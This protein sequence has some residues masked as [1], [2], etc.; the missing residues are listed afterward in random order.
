M[1]CRTPEYDYRDLAGSFA[2]PSCFYC[3]EPAS[4]IDHVPPKS[5]RFTLIGLGAQTIYPF[6]ELDCCRECNSALYNY[7]SATPAPKGAGLEGAVP[8]SRLT[9]LSSKR[10]YV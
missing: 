1:R 9:R 5:I 7:L 2:F 3:G 10:S 4:T 6:Y 8:T